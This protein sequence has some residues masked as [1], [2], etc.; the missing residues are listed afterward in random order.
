MKLPR[1][2]ALA[3]LAMMGSIAASWSAG[4]GS[5]GGGGLF[6]PGGGGG[7][8]SGNNSA[9]SGIVLT[10]GSAGT[11][12]GGCTGLACQVHACSGGGATTLSGTIY[13]PA[14]KN[15]L[16]GIVAYVPNSKPAPLTSG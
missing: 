1:R 13:D 14:G 11:S 16:Y 9:S 12:S 5:N 10:T 15:P 4:C 8:N 3:C 7:N 2:H 6:N